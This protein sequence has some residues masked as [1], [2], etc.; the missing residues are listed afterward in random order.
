M[1]KREACIRTALVLY[2]CILPGCAPK[3]DLKQS[4]AEVDRFHQR[5]NQ[6]YFTAVYNDADSHFR[7]AQ[8]P[9]LTIA[10]LQHNRNFFGAFKSAT[11]RS[12][13]I[14]SEQS[15]KDITLDYQCEYEHGT[16]S[17]LFV[18]RMTDGKPLLMKYFMSPGS[19][20][21]AGKG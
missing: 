8:T 21:K 5:W 13:K 16:A 3:D 4:E 2:I 19:D 9:Q 18:F 15:E 14:T 11:Q 20:A 10:Q 17:E 1:K 7:T 12:A 6:S